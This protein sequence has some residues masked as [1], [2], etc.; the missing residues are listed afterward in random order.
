MFYIPAAWCFRLGSKKHKLLNRLILPRPARLSAFA[1]RFG[2]RRDLLDGQIHAAR[3]TFEHSSFGKFPIIKLIEDRSERGSH[4]LRASARGIVGPN[5]EFVMATKPAEISEFLIVIHDGSFHNSVRFHISES[6]PVC[7]ES[8]PICIVE[9]TGGGLT[10][11]EHTWS[12]LEASWI[13]W[14]MQLSITDAEI[15]SIH[16]SIGLQRERKRSY[17]GDGQAG[18]YLAAIR[19]MQAEPHCKANSSQQLLD[20]IVK[21]A[22]GCR[23]SARNDRDI[24]ALIRELRAAEP[25]Y[26]ARMASAEN[27]SDHYYSL[28]LRAGYILPDAEWHVVQFIA[29]NYGR[30]TEVIEIGCGWGQVLVVLGVL[31][32]RC[33]GI[34]EAGSRLIGAEYLRRLVG[35]DYPYMVENVTYEVGNF[36]ESWKR[37]NTGERSRD[38][39]L[40]GF[41]SNLGIGSTD[42]FCRRCLEELKQFDAAIIDARRFFRARDA[43]EQDA[44]IASFNDFGIRYCCDVYGPPS[45]DYRFVL[46]YATDTRTSSSTSF[47]SFARRSGDP[48]HLETSSESDGPLSRR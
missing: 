38:R 41:F 26:A 29:Q 15:H 24:E 43:E 25:G 32:Y 12:A 22:A 35:A 20:D 6:A 17:T 44:L 28:R 36:P 48:Y 5:L 18:L 2:A 13:G 34:D 27:L 21:P 30:N 47:A 1:S 39:T 8:G 10:S 11:V 42:E 40:L 16:V 4:E 37:S 19:L 46:V 23:S 33:R 14:V 45:A 9:I 3:A 7:S 31:G